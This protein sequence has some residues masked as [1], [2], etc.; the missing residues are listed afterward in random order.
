VIAGK[1]ADEVESVKD[2]FED[3]KEHFES[4][5]VVVEEVA[6][7]ENARP[8]ALV[9]IEVIDLIMDERNRR[10]KRQE[11]TVQIADDPQWA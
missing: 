3:T 6:E 9:G 4:E 1:N 10:F 7:E 2:E 5:P 8:G 11:V